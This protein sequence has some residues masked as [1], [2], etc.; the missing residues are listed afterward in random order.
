V[1]GAGH[2]DLDGHGEEL[3]TR[4][5]AID[6]AVLRVFH[7]GDAARRAF[8]RYGLTTSLAALVRLEFRNLAAAVGGGGEGLKNA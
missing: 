1:H 4:E 2:L 5:E 3:V 7:R 6:E 8:R